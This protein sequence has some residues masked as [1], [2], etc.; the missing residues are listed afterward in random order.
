MPELPEVETIVRELR[1]AHL[2]GATITNVEVF[3]PRIVSPHTVEEFVRTVS[4]QKIRSIVRRAKYIVFNLDKNI[5]TVHLRM[6][7]KVFLTPKIEPVRKHI[8]LRLHLAD[9]R[10]LHYEDQRKFGRWTLADISSDKLSELGIEPLS[11][12]FTS[13]ILY[14]LLQSHMMQ[15]KPFLLNQ[16][17]IAGLGNI[18]VD[19]ALWAAKIHPQ[20]ITK[21]ISKQQATLLHK[22]IRDVLERGIANAGTSLGNNKSNY[23]SLSG[24]RGGNQYRLNVFRREGLPCPRCNT[25]IV[26]IKVA[27]R[28]T[29]ICPHCQ[30]LKKK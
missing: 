12:E 19:E 20:S 22:T 26:K 24:K 4:K 27:Q 6:T 3:W 2:E 30:K 1:E 21:T 18:Y 28:G 13:P 9:G 8:H 10:I 5:L 16:K 15:M 25:T 7:G 14:D 23:A 29:H 17:F 11:D